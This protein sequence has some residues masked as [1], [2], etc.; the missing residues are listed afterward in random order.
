MEEKQIRITFVPV[1]HI[2]NSSPALVR[3]AIE[4]EN[5]QLIGVELCRERLESMV[6]SPRGPSIGTVIAHPTFAIMFAA[7]QLLGKWWN[8]KPGEEMREALRVAGEMQKPIVLLDRNMSATARQ[9]E[10]I[11]FKEKVGLL[12]SGGEL[13]K[14]QR[15][16][17]PHQ[18]EGACPNPFKN[19]KGVPVHLQRVRGIK[20]QAH[21]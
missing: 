13:P 10:K 18:S 4:K 6:R 3:K 5:P 1:A 2:S 19:G 15:F 11:P 14:N 12:F 21:G 20:E 7:Q 8:L 9:I 17:Q 16:F